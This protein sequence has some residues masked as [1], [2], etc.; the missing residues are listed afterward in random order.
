MKTIAQLVACAERELAIRKNVYPKW[1]GQKLTADRCR[2]EIECMEQIVAL[3]KDRT[4]PP[5]REDLF[6]AD[7]QSHE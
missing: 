4:Q 5:P 3:L 1:I 6:P 7:S 2:H